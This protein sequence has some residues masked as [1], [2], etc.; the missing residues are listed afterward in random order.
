M[1]DEVNE[2]IVRF[3]ELGYTIEMVIQA[4]SNEEAKKIALKKARALDKPKLDWVEIEM[5]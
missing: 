3:E 1:M 5:L 2:Y 4:T